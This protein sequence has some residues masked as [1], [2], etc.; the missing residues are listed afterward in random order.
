MLIYC[1]GDSFT[2]GAELA[3][4]LLPN[5]P[6]YSNTN[7][8]N[9]AKENFL[10]FKDL[11]LKKY[12]VKR[13]EITTD[14]DTFTLYD[15]DKT[16]DFPVDPLL[17]GILQIE[18]NRAWPNKISLLD[19]SIKIINNS[20]GGAGITGICQRAIADLIELKE[21]GTTVDLVIL[22]LTAT[23]RYEIYDR[24]IYKNFMY[25]RTVHSGLDDIGAWLHPDDCAIAHA[26]LKKYTGEDYIIKYLYTLCSAVESIKS[27]TGKYPLIVDSMNQ[28]NLLWDADNLLRHFLKLD[29]KIGIKRANTL[30][31]GSRIKSMHQTNMESLIT[32]FTHPYCVFGHYSTDVQNLFAKEIYQLIQSELK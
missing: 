31:N 9:S 8:S 28:K 13:E 29:D 5:W 3:D 32:N 17:S 4:D 16:Y 18:K 14:S 15:A 2:A 20:I 27:L 25:E 11:A 1:N 12:V 30:I 26:V 22:Q 10:K 7:K 6:G 21:E 24:D 23:I 19:P